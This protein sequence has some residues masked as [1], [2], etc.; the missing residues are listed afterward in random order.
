[1]NIGRLFRR[2][3][4]PLVQIHFHLANIL[5]RKRFAIIAKTIYHERFSIL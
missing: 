1:M 2:E 3:L 5:I 4:T